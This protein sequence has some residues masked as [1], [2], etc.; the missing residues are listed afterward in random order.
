MWEDTHRLHAAPPRSRHLQFGQ[1]VKKRFRGAKRPDTLLTH[2]NTHPL[3]SRRCL[4]HLTSPH[5]TEM[6]SDNCLQDTAEHPSCTLPHARPTGDPQQPPRGSLHASGGG[7]RRLPAPRSPPAA[8]S[9]RKPHRACAPA[10][11]TGA[12][13]RAPMQRAPSCAALVTQRG[14]AGGCARRR[15]C[16]AAAP[17]HAH[18]CCRQ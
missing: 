10:A 5:L 18:C 11:C 3:R 6:Q 13:S 16:K 15:V 4:H 17:E 12:A 8:T 9:A 14:R 2:P 1:R 7:G